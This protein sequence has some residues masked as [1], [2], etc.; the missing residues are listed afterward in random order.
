MYSNCNGIFVTWHVGNLQVSF[1]ATFILL[2]MCKLENLNHCGVDKRFE[3]YSTALIGI[4]W[5]LALYVIFSN[6]FKQIFSVKLWHACTCAMPCH[7]VCHYTMSAQNW[8]M[9][10]KKNPIWTL[11]HHIVFFL[12]KWHMTQTCQEQMLCRCQYLAESL[13]LDLFKGSVNSPWAYLYH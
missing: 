13:R 8:T 11:I 5:W 9:C 2:C 7:E 6:S 4:C 3:S 1:A 12:K 10:Y